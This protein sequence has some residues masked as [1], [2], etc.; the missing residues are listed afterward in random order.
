VSVG[1]CGQRTNNDDDNDDDD[2]DDDDDDEALRS[3]RLS[4]PLLSD[5]AVLWTWYVVWCGVWMRACFVVFEVCLAEKYLRLCL[6][7]V[8]MGALPCVICYS[9]DV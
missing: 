8:V 4:L 3:R 2:D 9:S 6:C 7:R 1:R 5:E